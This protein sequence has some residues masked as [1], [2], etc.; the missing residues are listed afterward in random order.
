MIGTRRNTRPGVRTFAGGSRQAD[1]T[2]ALVQAETTF[3]E[4]LREDIQRRKLEE[5]PRVVAAEYA[6]AAAQIDVLEADEASAGDDIR[7]HTAAR[8]ALSAT[9]AEPV[10]ICGPIQLATLAEPRTS[11]LSDAAAREQVATTRGVV[12]RGHPIPAFNELFTPLS[13]VSRCPNKIL[14][15]KDVCCHVWAA[16]EGDVFLYKHRSGQWVFS[17]KIK[18]NSSDKILAR[19]ATFRL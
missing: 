13:D 2:S 5:Q 17:S 4:Q 19:L 3:Q 15:C 16:S 9:A 10:G 18:Q 14:P 1:E 6:D 8:V 11:P 12:V 7:H